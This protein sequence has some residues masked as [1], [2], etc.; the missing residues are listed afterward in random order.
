MLAAVMA[1]N[2]Y[3][4]FAA[5]QPPYFNQSRALLYAPTWYN[6]P[7]S[8]KMVMCRSNPA[9]PEYRY[10][11]QYSSNRMVTTGDE[12]DMAPVLWWGLFRGV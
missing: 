6:L 1:L 2:A 12:P 10:H 9:L 3:S 5:C 11:D 4:V 8:L 7:W